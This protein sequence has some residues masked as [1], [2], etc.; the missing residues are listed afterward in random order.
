MYG[1]THDVQKVAGF[2]AGSQHG[3]ADVGRAELDRQAGGHT[4]VSGEGERSV[5][6]VVL[7]H[8]TGGNQ[9]GSTSK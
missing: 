6:M 2:H 7:P 4:Q 3:G 8:T 9:E 5:P 1:V